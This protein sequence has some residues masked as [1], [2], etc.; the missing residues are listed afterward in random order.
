MV[1]PLVLAP[2]YSRRCYS[3]A[4]W[5]RVSPRNRN[6]GP[7]YHLGAKSSTRGCLRR[8]SCSRRCHSKPGAHPGFRIHRLGCD[9]CGASVQ[10]GQ[11]SETGCLKGLLEPRVGCLRVLI[12]NVVMMRK[13]Q[14]TRAFL[15]SLCCLVALTLSTRGAP[16]IKQATK[17][18]AQ[19]VHG[20]LT[21]SNGNPSSR[22]WIVGTRRVLGVRESSDEVA[23][24]PRELRAWM[25]W[26][27]EIFADFVVEPLTSYKPGVMQMVRVLSASNIVVM[28]GEK[29]LLKKP[30]L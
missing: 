28:E 8:F 20:R 17:A 12:V 15:L 25:A 2:G 7:A 23:Y 9:F 10:E 5:V 13:S 26:N 16:G 1:G 19:I 30:K 14:C 29:I 24:M 11:G 21:Y 6:P 27:R 3:M 4:Y 22:I 18:Q